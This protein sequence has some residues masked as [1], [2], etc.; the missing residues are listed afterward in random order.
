MPRKPHK[1]LFTGVFFPYALMLLLTSTHWMKE[2]RGAIA[3]AMSSVFVQNPSEKKLES[4]EGSQLHPPNNT[5]YLVIQKVLCLEHVFSFVESTI[6][7]IILI[8]AYINK[9]INGLN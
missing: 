6:D 9:H 7:P 1:K 8:Q 3:R 4:T 5:R 2:Q